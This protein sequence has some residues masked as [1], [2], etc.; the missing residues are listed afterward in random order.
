MF[1]E[2]GLRG[3]HRQN[4]EIEQEKLRV[5]FLGLGE[6]APDDPVTTLAVASTNG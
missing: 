3:R 6:K 2:W 1:L 4:G 5:R